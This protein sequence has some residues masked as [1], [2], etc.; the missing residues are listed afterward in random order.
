M[1]FKFT[2]TTY[3]TQF[4][5]FGS[6]SKPVLTEFEGDLTLTD[7]DLLRIGQLMF[8]AS[9]LMSPKGASPKEAAEWGKTVV[10]AVKKEKL[11]GRQSEYNDEKREEHLAG[12]KNQPTRDREAKIEMEQ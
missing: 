10:E 4:T 6:K 5:E 1:R 3:L 11:V 9:K 7:M 12:L 2:A 8:T